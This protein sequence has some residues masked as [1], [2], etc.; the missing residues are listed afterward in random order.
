M[1]DTGA[2]LPIGLWVAALGATGFVAGFFGPIALNPDANQGPL[3]GIFITGPGGAIG[4][5]IA[6]LL[7]RVL[8]VSNGVRVGAL[9][10]ATGALGLGTLWF[11]LPQ[12][13]V[14][15][16][17]IDAT[18][19]ECARPADLAKDALARWQ[20][21]VARATW[22]TP[23][24]DW[25]QRA[26]GNLDRDPGVVL[27]LHVE[28]RATIRQHRKPWDFGRMDAA[29]WLPTTQPE[30]YYADDEGGSCAAYLARPRQL[31]LPHAISP[32]NP[33]EPAKVWP[34]VDTTGFLSLLA[35]GGVP[36]TYRRLIDLR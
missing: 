5:L 25:Q 19:A 11:C 7:F 35:L 23:P 24:A 3:L 4:G 6:G 22:V 12:P 30:R 10:S 36:E 29:P 8:P 2:R 32:G 13:A 20:A 26:L 17:V 1:N 31:Y 28:R 9:L 34:P 27:T 16:Y 14:L 21:A 33:N 15:G 18:V